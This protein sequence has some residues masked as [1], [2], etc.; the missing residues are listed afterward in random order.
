MAAVEGSA[1]PFETADIEVVALDKALEAQWMYILRSDLPA[2][3]NTGALG[4]PLPGEAITL[5]LMA[6]EARTD[7]IERIRAASDGAPRALR[8]KTTEERWGAVL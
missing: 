4:G 7:M 2:R 1:I 6:F 8:V 3:F 5:A